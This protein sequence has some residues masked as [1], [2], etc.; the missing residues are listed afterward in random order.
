MNA[1]RG[2]K[3]KQTLIRNRNFFPLLLL[4][5]ACSCGLSAH[6]QLPTE[7]V[8]GYVYVEPFEVRKEIAFRLSATGESYG[9]LITPVIQQKLIA[10]F[11]KQFET[12]NPMFI[13]EQPTEMALDRLQFVKIIPDLGVFPDDRE[14]I[15]ASEAL[16]A[17][18]YVHVTEGFPKQIDLDWTYFPGDQTDI[19]V[20]FVTPNTR[21]TKRFT[22]DQP[23][24][25]W[26]V[27][28]T[29]K[30]PT[31][32]DFGLTAENPKIALPGVSLIL[33][34]LILIVGIGSRVLKQPKLLAI[35]GLIAIL[36][37][38][39]TFT[40]WG[41][42]KFEIRDFTVN[43]EIP[44]SEEAS[45]LVNTILTNVY[46]GFDFREEEKIYDTLAYSVEGETLEKLYL[47]MRSG[48]ELED[49]GGPRVK[50]KSIDLR[51]CY[52]EAL[53]ER[54]GFRADTEWVAVGEVT[55]WG[56]THQRINV[57]RAWLA[58]EPVEGRWKLT[59]IDIIEEGRL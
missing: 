20:T 52:P 43:P 12:A 49:Q 38:F 59:D 33:I 56:H 27:P 46:H 57:Y 35:C 47:E 36:S 30:E 29:E 26:L 11:T 6:A 1:D 24:N 25:S 9:E 50:I 53:G 15:P 13:D 34:A 41:L 4:I 16:L 8:Q 22:R 51:G 7:P 45:S 44:T 2:N 55:H 10:D 18:V 28:S 39:G 14:Q 23:R 32:V 40:L 58:V 19:P 54:Q 48:L 5:A 3:S 37:M 31:L 21:S 17:A 42:G